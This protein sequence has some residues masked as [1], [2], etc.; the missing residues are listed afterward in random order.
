MSASRHAAPVETRTGIAAAL[1]RLWA[2]QT[3]LCTY[4]ALALPAGIAIIL[5]DTNPSGYDWHHHWLRAQQVAH[6]GW[7]PVQSSTDPGH[8]GSF[9]NGSFEEFN[10]TA[11]NS[12]FEYLPALLGFGHYRVACLATLAFCALTT[13]AAI[14]LS[15]RL[16]WV[17]AAI[18][19]LPSVFLSSLYPTAD[20]VIDSVSLLFLAMVLRVYDQRRRATARQCCAL[21][22]LALCVGQIKITCVLL[23]ALL[24]PLMAPPSD[25]GRHFDARPAVPLAAGVGSFLAWHAATR[26]IPPVSYYSSAQIA[27]RTHHV[28]THPFDLLR[29]TVVTLV[30]PVDVAGAQLAQD[31]GTSAQEIGKHTEFLV[32]IEHTMVPETFML[33]AFVALGIMLLLSAAPLPAASPSATSSSAE[34]LPAT[35]LPC[36]EPRRWDAPMWVCSAAVV[37]AYTIATVAAMAVISPSDGTGGWVL[38]L[39][40]RYFIPLLPLLLVPLA[41]AD[42]RLGRQREAR[43]IATGLLAF[44]YLGIVVCHVAF[45]PAGLNVW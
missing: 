14:V 39:Q 30:K 5:F 1:T 10:N 15:S 41:N 35:S 21:T 23:L 36:R 3:A 6:G 11:V 32:G 18:G 17:F 43:R 45:A 9:V 27:A 44:A 24:I 28:L 33:P 2:R 4:L 25:E 7:L 42:L 8:Y 22:V 37:A 13:G 40:S 38:G 12:P 20:A 26:G 31:P 19:L 34:L 29:S 16:S